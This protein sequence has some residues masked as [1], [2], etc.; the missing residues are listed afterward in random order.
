MT[1][2]R[3]TYE[4]LLS[5]IEGGAY[6]NLAL[7]EA[8]GK[9]PEA[10]VGTL[11]AWV[12]TA[13]EHRSYVEY[14]LSHFCKRQKKAVRILL[15]L[16]TT[17][18]LYLNTPAH[19]AIFET[20]S[21]CKSIGKADS[22]ALVNA[23]LRRVDR[24]RDSLPPLPSDPIE[25]LSIRY[26]YPKWIAE[27]WIASHGIGFA[28]RMMQSRP[29]RMQVRAQF[30]TSKEELLR[31]FPGSV[32]GKLDP[33]CLY[34]PSGIDLEQNPL[35]CN[36]KMTAQNEGAMLICRSLGDVRK[37][38]VLDVCAAPGGKTAY[39]ASLF[40]NDISL[41]AWELHPHRKELMDATFLRLHVD[42]VTEC[43]D[44]TV[45]YEDAEESFDAVLLDVP[46]T[47]LGL[48][49]DKPDVRYRKTEAD[50]DA[51][52]SVQSK[53]LSVCSRYVKPGGTLVYATCTIS[54]KENELQVAGF[55]KQHPDYSLVS[56]RQYL[57]ETD[58]IDGFYHATMRRETV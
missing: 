30:P 15:L 12:Y 16:G 49:S 48:L 56:E 2:R 25:Q 37:K 58:G 28:E 40:E 26:G 3:V 54:R 52:V 44:G 8:A 45:L 27:E 38:R 13:L 34:L 50:R 7:K 10:G 39:L 35:W 43:R 17:E 9:V 53:L 20:V 51:I 57:P 5:I 55:L 11:Y 47:G 6:A 42:A 41:T 33:N 24:G 46:C 36:G 19:A 23:V 32:S 18:L 29:T 31:A 14:I 1:V 22:A 21:L 4:T